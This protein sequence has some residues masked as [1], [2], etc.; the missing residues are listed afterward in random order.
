MYCL[1]CHQKISRWR[2]LKTGSQYC[3]EEHAEQH[4]REAMGRLLEYE[5]PATP[6]THEED[7]I[8][9]L[10]VITSGIQPPAQ[11]AP[12]WQMQ[13]F[14]EVAIRRYSAPRKQL[15]PALPGQEHIPPRLRLPPRPKPLELWTG[16][17]R[18]ASTVPSPAVIRAHPAT[19]PVTR[20]PWHAPARPASAGPSRLA[21]KRPATPAAAPSR[22]APLPSIPAPP[23]AVPMLPLESGVFVLAMGPPDLVNGHRNGLQNLLP[24]LEPRKAARLLQPAGRWQVNFTPAD[25]GASQGAAKRRPVPA[26]PAAATQVCLWPDDRACTALIGQGVRGMRP[27]RRFQ[28]APAALAAPAVE[29]A[30]PGAGLQSVAPQMSLVVPAAYES[31]APARWKQAASSFRPLA[32]SPHPGAPAAVREFDG[33]LWPSRAGLPRRV[34]AAPVP[35]QLWHP[36]EMIQRARPPQ[37]QPVK[38]QKVAALVKPAPEL[39][40]AACTVT[41]QRRTVPALALRGDMDGLRAAG[42]VRLSGGFFR[43]AA[44]RGRVE[45]AMLPASAGL[46][47]RQALLRGSS[48]RPPPGL[49]ER[50]TRPA[51]LPAGPAWLETTKYGDA[52]A[53]QLAGRG[54]VLHPGQCLPL[55]PRPQFPEAS[56]SHRPEVSLEAPPIAVLLLTGSRGQP[57]A[58]RRTGFACDYR[59]LMPEAQLQ[60]AAHRRVA[61]PSVAVPPVAVRL[62][63]G[64]RTQRS[65]PSGDARAAA[66]AAVIPAVATP[67][68]ARLPASASL[69]RSADVL[70]QRLRLRAAAPL[71]AGVRRPAFFTAAPVAWRTSAGGALPGSGLRPAGVAPPRSLEEERLRRFATV[72]VKPAGRVDAA[73]SARERPLP[74]P[75]EAAAAPPPAPSRPPRR[76]AESAF[77]LPAAR[78]AP[79]LPA[80][81]L[82]PELAPGR[83]ASPEQEPPHSEQPPLLREHRLLE[84]EPVE[85]IDIAPP[86]LAP[87]AAPAPPA[88]APAGADSLR[89]ALEQAQRKRRIGLQQV[90]TAASNTWQEVLLPAVGTRAGRLVLI[91]G[92]LLVV[93]FVMGRLVAGPMRAAV[94]SVTQ[95][96]TVRSFFLLE[97]KFGSGFADWSEPAGL[98]R[99]NDG[100][101]EIREGLTLYRPSIARSDYAFS[102]EGMVNQGA[103]GWVARAA[104]SRNY[105]AFKL[106]WRGRGRDRRSVLLRYPILQ[107]QA[108]EADQTA[109]LALPFDL[110]ENTMYRVDMNIA[111]DRLTT[112]IDGRGVDSFSDALL[113]SGGV[114]FFAEKGESARIHSLTVSGNDD[115]TGRAIAWLRGFYHFLESGIS[116][117]QR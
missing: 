44:I 101:V 13:P 67:D 23:V 7:L 62:L 45:T 114:G 81:P 89:D 48:L 3:C 8:H 88:P 25:R 35:R 16:G 24:G 47:D 61:V 54:E 43:P 50:K 37:E 99:Q 76:Y 9:R 58:P 20:S 100:L 18:S 4:K 83:H 87:P 33:R 2:R 72:Q 71:A 53:M 78:P 39:L 10:S 64:F 5:Q 1:L 55:W 66:P 90:V 96:L 42:G 77:G 111:G 85:R 21:A 104:D 82:A 107:G 14:I 108:P 26:A 12:E 92:G 115:P 84:A 6:H 117:S 38:E 93:F 73:T 70:Q 106:T 86:L 19:P 17:A 103:L 15:R 109:V 112:M 34:P 110:K 80:R 36:A 95:P 74:T 68:A 105:H 94:Q 29:A 57:L 60:A 41:P 46:D 69:Y 27:V 113:K 63:A 31:I 49:A 56:L 28:P 75:A 59:F 65:R 102:F 79:P 32:A 40:L 97:E 51:R 30:V 91:L 116:G 52:A 98:S 11:S 22:S